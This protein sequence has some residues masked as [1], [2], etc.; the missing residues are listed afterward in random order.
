VLDRFPANF[1]LWVNTMQY[2]RSLQFGGYPFQQ[3]DLTS[4]EWMALSTLKR[5]EVE[6]QYLNQN[7]TE[8]S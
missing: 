8:E 3:N 4:H 7:A 5:F 6:N 2:L 1:G